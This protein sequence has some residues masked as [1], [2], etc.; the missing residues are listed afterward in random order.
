MGKEMESVVKP[1][2][3]AGL[4]LPD[5]IISFLTTILLYV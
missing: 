2:K 3:S 5:D 4:K 1:G